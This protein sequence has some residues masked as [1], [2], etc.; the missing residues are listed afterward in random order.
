MIEESEEALC[1]RGRGAA[2]EV[3]QAPQQRPQHAL[4]EGTLALSNL[5]PPGKARVV[6]SKGVGR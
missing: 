2:G 4:A 5:A 6:G 1:G 3:L